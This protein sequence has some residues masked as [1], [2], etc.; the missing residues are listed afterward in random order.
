MSEAD[1]T[2]E[3]LHDDIEEWR[4]DRRAKRV[5]YARKYWAFGVP[6]NGI[7]VAQTGVFALTGQD[8]AFVAPDRIGLLLEGGGSLTL[9]GGGPLLLE[10]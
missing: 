1:V 7:M 10:G 4:L 2:L 9:E 8:V 6:I 5:A 3:T